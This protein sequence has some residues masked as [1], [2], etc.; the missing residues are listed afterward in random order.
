MNITKQKLLNCGK[1]RKYGK[2]STHSDLPY[3]CFASM[4]KYKLSGKAREVVCKAIAL[5]HALTRAL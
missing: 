5:S 2:Q 3:G 4:S 1:Q